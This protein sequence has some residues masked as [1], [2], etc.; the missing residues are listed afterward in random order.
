M[1]LLLAAMHRHG[2]YCAKE[3]PHGSLPK[4]NLVQTPHVIRMSV[5]LCT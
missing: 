3:T 5:N 1:D 4:V 2:S